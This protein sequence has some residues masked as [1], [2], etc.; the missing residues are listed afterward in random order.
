MKHRLLSALLVLLIAVQAVS[1]QTIKHKPIKD[2]L[3]GIRSEKTY[4]EAKVY[5]NDTLSFKALSQSGEWRE[6]IEHWVGFYMNSSNSPEEFTQAFIPQAKKVLTRTLSEDKQV[7]LTLT[8]DLITF[9][10][11]YALDTAAEQVA[12][13]ASKQGLKSEKIA[14]LVIAAEMKGKPAPRIEGVAD[15]SNSLIIFYESGCGNCDT[16]MAILKRDYKKLQEKGIRV[17]SVSADED[18]LIFYSYTKEL[19]W[20]DKPCDFRGLDGKAFQDY[21]VISTPTIF[22]TDS[23]GKIIGRYARLQDTG[24]L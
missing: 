18:P 24:A 12:V 6:Y 2:L 1:G 9:F 10:E 15:L 4:E 17:I 14:R 21:G 11:Q 23:Q 5:I 13:S 16:E 19:P 8:N 20:S 7:A 22:R 3:A